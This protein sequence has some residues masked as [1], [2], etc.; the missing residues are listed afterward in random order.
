[1]PI[2]GRPG[3]LT[4]GGAL[5]A[6]HQDAF[7]VHRYLGDLNAHGER[8]FADTAKQHSATSGRD[9]CLRGSSYD[10]IME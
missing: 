4:T 1:M 6:V 9:T 3:L 8:T 2:A 5:L 7:T 10:Q